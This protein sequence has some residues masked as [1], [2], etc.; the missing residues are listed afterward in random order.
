[1]APS[2]PKKERQGQ[3]PDQK[4]SKER[5]MKLKSALINYAKKS[6]DAIKG[7]VFLITEF[8]WKSDQ[9]QNE[10]CRFCKLSKFK[11]KN[12]IKSLDCCRKS[13]S[14]GRKSTCIPWRRFIRR[15]GTQATLPRFTWYE[16]YDV[17]F[18]MTS[19]GR[20][21]YV[22]IFQQCAIAQTNNFM[23]LNSNIQNRRRK[24]R[25]F[26]SVSPILNVSF[27][28]VLIFYEFRKHSD[29]NRDQKPHQGLFSS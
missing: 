12:T 7:M 19:S 2:V 4:M 28:Q 10:M 27:F 14:Y 25:N 18:T 13:Q 11:S 9:F 20:H 1:M 8:Q 21:Y 3:Q 5:A 22:I 24:K 26:R 29:L 6:N 16:L 23:T 17:I 15:G